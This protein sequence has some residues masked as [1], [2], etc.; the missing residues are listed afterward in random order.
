MKLIRF[1]ERDLERYVYRIYPMDRFIN[2]LECK[3]LTLVK[4]RLWKDPMETIIFESSF[5]VAGIRDYALKYTENY[6]A[7]CW[8]LKHESLALWNE[9]APMK[10]GVRVRTTLKKLKEILVGHHLN[11]KDSWFLGKIEYMSI[12]EIKKWIGHN[13]SYCER[14]CMSKLPFGQV[15]ALLIKLNQYSNENEIRIILNSDANPDINSKDIYND[16]DIDPL[17][18][19]ETIMI[20]PRMNESVYK[21]FKAEMLRYGFRKEQVIQSGLLN[22]SS[23]RKHLRYI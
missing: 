8:T 13:I 16:I 11:A 20:D 22:P 17:N 6:F 23:L 19:F 3:K 1:H 9:Y 14:V 18:L 4:P 10:D 15:H 5:N 2:L 21:I 7:Q 12:K